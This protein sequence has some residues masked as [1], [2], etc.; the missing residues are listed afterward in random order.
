MGLI[1]ALHVHEANIHDS[2]GARPTL[3]KIGW[4]EYPRLEVVFADSAY[5]GPLPGFV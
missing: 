4:D 3:S 1:H 5:Q 2:V